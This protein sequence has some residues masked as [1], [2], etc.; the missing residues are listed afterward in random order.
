M[1]FDSVSEGVRDDGRWRL[2]ASKKRIYLSIK[3]EA[4]ELEFIVDSLS[5]DEL[6]L[7]IDAPSDSDAKNLKI[8]F[9]Y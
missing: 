7:I 9:K 2:D 5:S 1:T 8:Y 3:G 4:G 6:I